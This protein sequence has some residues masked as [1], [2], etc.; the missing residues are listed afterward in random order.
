MWPSHIRNWSYFKSSPLFHQLFLFPRSSIPVRSAALFGSCRGHT[1]EPLG[2]KGK[3]P[4]HNGPF[5]SYRLSE[6]WDEQDSLLVALEAPTTGPGLQGSLQRSSLFL[7]FSLLK[8]KKIIFQI[9]LFY[10]L[11]ISPSDTAEWSY[12]FVDKA[13]PL[14][15]LWVM[16]S[17]CSFKV[18]ILVFWS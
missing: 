9:F 12:L 11:W 10:F 18:L 6:L 4:F 16:A 15:R 17:L 14:R 1:E 5:I 3:Y 13:V 8:Q 2:A 7:I